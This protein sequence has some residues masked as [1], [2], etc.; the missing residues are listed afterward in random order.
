MDAGE[1]VIEHF[2][3]SYIIG[4]PIEE[5]NV[6]LA[7]AET[8]LVEA[9]LLQVTCE[10]MYGNPTGQFNLSLPGLTKRNPNTFKQLSYRQ[11]R[12]NLQA[13][14]PAD[15]PEDETVYRGGQARA[16]E[17]EED[18]ESLLEDEQDDFP[19]KHWHMDSL[20][21]D[22]LLRLEVSNKAREQVKCEVRLVADEADDTPL[23]C[24]LPVTPFY[25]Q[26]FS[27]GV[28]ARPVMALLHKIDPSKPFGKIKLEVSAK[29]IR[30]VGGVSS[31]SALHGVSSRMDPTYTE[32][33]RNVVSQIQSGDRGERGQQ[34]ND[35]FVT[36]VG[37]SSRRRNG[38]TFGPPVHED[39]GMEEEVV[40]DFLKVEGSD[41]IPESR[42]G[43]PNE[44]QRDNLN[45]SN[46]S[47]TALV[48]DGKEF[49][50][51]NGGSSDNFSAGDYG[52]GN[53]L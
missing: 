1:G 26:L 51:A 33:F 19:V 39:A 5:M 16:E 7:T 3:P 53:D 13:G 34:V 30:H 15:E 49:G 52:I 47:T 8:D 27:T 28:S 25:S 40:E 10:W 36:G 48:D 12:K 2:P 43:Q 42:Y 18:D 24:K 22:V 50:E 38:V 37:V 23:N 21:G 6:E 17:D 44:D 46:D 32:S 45:L 31:T 11:Y 35:F 14:K 20:I 4:A 29:P 41:I 9:R